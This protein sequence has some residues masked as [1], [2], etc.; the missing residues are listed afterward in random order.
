MSHTPSFCPRV[1]LSTI[2][3]E[4]GRYWDLL[5][6]GESNRT[7]HCAAQDVPTGGR[8]VVAADPPEALTDSGYGTALVELAEGASTAVTITVTAEDVGEQDY[9][10]VI[11]RAVA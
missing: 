4:L 1:P 11:H 10:A 5:P 6:Y 8:F 7:H 2:T 3:T 9:T